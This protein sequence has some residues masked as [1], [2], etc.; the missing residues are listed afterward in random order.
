MDISTFRTQ[1][2]RAHGKEQIYEGARGGSK[3]STDK[4]QFYPG[5]STLHFYATKEQGTHYIA[6]STSTMGQGSKRHIWKHFYEGPMS[7][8]HNWKLSNSVFQDG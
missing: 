2:D 6:R 8:R 5:H 3:Y 7:R 4:K 1:R